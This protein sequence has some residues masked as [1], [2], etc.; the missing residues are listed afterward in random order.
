MRRVEPSHDERYKWFAP[1]G[2][3]RYADEQGRTWG[4]PGAPSRVPSLADGVAQKAWFCGTPAEV[5]D[6]IKSIEAQISRSRGFHDPLGRGSAARRVQGAAALVRSR[7]D[8]G[9]YP[10]L[11]R[12]PAGVYNFW[13]STGAVGL[14]VGGVSSG[15]S[16][17]AGR[18]GGRRSCDGR[19]RHLRTGR[20]TWADFD[21]GDDA[22][23]TRDTAREIGRVIEFGLGCAPNRSNIPS[24]WPSRSCN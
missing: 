16:G 3:V 4:M 2:F 20:G 11:G 15:A 18:I 14:A 24:G 10:R 7:R 6:G 9:L 21:I 22:F 1:F 5:I 19:S 23:D 12:Q 8:A 13:T 17:W